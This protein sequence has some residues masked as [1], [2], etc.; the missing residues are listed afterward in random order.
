MDSICRMLAYFP[1]LK[2]AFPPI[3]CGLGGLDRGEVLSIIYEKTKGY[4]NNLYLIGW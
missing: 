3:G 2:V 1:N 4:K